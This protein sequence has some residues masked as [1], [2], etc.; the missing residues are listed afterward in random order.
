MTHLCLYYEISDFLFGL[1]SDGD[2]NTGSRVGD[3]GM[4]DVNGM[5]LAISFL[6]N[7]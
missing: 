5:Q 6:D 2:A 3:V 4:G 1:T 7:Q